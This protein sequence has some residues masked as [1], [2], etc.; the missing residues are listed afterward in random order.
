MKRLEC[1]KI[2]WLWM[3]YDIEQGCVILEDIIYVGYYALLS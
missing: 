2:Y 3:K 1:C